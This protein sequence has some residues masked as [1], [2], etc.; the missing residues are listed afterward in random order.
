MLVVR[1]EDARAFWAGVEN[2]TVQELADTEAA[3]VQA[4]KDLLGDDAPILQAQSSV[5]FLQS[6]VPGKA[7]AVLVRDDVVCDL[8]D[9]E[10]Y[11]DGVEIMARAHLVSIDDEDGSVSYP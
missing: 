8:Q 10:P 4:V 2:K 1:D 11:A 6:P 7:Y 3:A 9:R 5:V